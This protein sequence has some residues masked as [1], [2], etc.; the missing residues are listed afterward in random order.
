[1]RGARRKEFSSEQAMTALSQMEVMRA[2]PVFAENDCHCERSQAHAA[3]AV[4][5][6][7]GKMAVMCMA[8][9]CPPYRRLRCRR[10]LRS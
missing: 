3:G 7:S 8:K 5:A 1:M 2:E 9:A 4:T 10:G 6:S